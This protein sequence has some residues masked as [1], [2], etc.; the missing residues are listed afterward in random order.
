FEYMV[1]SGATATPA[2]W[3]MVGALMASAGTTPAKKTTASKAIVMI[4][5]RTEL[6][7]QRAGPEISA[8]STLEGTFMHLPHVNPTNFVHPYL[9]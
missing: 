5:L 3:V 9:L 8:N 6:Q 1:V 2:T 4:N 7:S